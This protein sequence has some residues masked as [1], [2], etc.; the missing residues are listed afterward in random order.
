MVSFEF[1]DRLSFSKTKLD[2]LIQYLYGLTDLPLFEILSIRSLSSSFTDFDNFE[3]VYE[4]VY[5]GDSMDRNFIR[6]V[7]FPDLNDCFFEEVFSLD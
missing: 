7:L 4:V 3:F 6:V 2:Y 5:V 1:F